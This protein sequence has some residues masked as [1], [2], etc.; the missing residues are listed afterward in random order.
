MGRRHAEDAA[1]TLLTMA[2]ASRTGSSFGSSFGSSCGIRTRICRRN[3]SRPFTSV[4]ASSAPCGSR[5]RCQRQYHQPGIWARRRQ[6]AT[7]ND[8]GH[9]AVVGG[10]LTGL[11]TAYYLA[12]QLPSTAKITLYEGSDRLGGWIRTDRV[13]VDVGGVKGTVSFERGPRTLS[14]LHT[15]AWR[16]DDLILYDLALNLG[17][18]V[19]T[20]PDQPRYIY[21][22]DHIVTLPPAASLA[23]FV[24]E[25][26]FLQSFFAGLGFFLRRLRSRAV[27]LKDTSIS[28]W[29]YEVSGSRS[30]AENFASAMIHGIYGGD[31][32][33]LSARSVFDRF[34]WA[35]YLPNLGPHVK[36]MT[37]REQVLM[38]ELSKDPEIRRMAL[39]AQGTLLHFGKA[40][41]ES[42]PK[43]LEHVL[44]KTANVEI[45]KGRPVRD[46]SYDQEMNKM[47]IT[48]GSWEEVGEDIQHQKRQHALR[49]STSSSSSA[50]ASTCTYDRVIS[51]LT[52]QD[53]AR[54]TGDKLPSLAK[55]HSVS[56]MTVNL[57]Y[58]KEN[59]KPPG[60]GYLIPRSVSPEHNME[61]ALGVFYDSDVGA[62][63]SP[64]EPPGTKL[65]VLMGGHYYDSGAP[66]PSEA[67]AV[68]QAKALLE[69][70]LGIPIDTPCFALSRFAKECIP[71]HFVGH[72]DRMMQADRELR[73]HF[74]GRLAVAGGSYS[75]IGA[76][77]SIR[78][79]YD[80]AK[81]T[82]STSDGW[83][84]TGLESLEFPEKIVGVPISSIPV[85]RFKPRG[86]VMGKTEEKVRSG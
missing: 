11:T 14:S 64:D 44:S 43:A 10:G 68:D 62:A 33:K 75:K 58:P 51:T 54:L 47:K 78:A 41:M 59:L 27:P 61:R 39:K 81:Q 13:P 15:S 55:S 71:Q 34:Y 30:V 35:Y 25:P 63:A 19:F 49:Q 74:A 37:T 24:R 8:S 50:S 85:R 60:F 38:T 3:T 72:T 12:K 6:Y 5:P 73:D 52:S 84:T 21:Y 42:L 46:I 20:P 28:E 69:R 32:D 1:M 77:G 57:W 45:K 9:I 48:T 80:I 66:P 83:Y 26:L 76:M 18:E 56:I 53:L 70:H 22:P 16:F 40:G 82:V 86:P 29:L 17:L 79:G 31:I 65:F 4:H 67:D 36:H 7:L 23:Q 2:S